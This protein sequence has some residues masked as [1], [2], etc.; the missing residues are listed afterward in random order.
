MKRIISS[1]ALLLFVTPLAPGQTRN[2]PQLGVYGNLIGLT[3]TYGNDVFSKIPRPWR[4]GYAIAYS[5]RNY[6]GRPEQRLIYVFGDQLN[7][8]TFRVDTK[9]S[10][11]SAKIVITEDKALEIR[12]SFTWD[13]KS[14][15]LKT[16][17]T[18]TNVAVFD[19]RIIGVEFQFDARLIGPRDILPLPPCPKPLQNVPDACECDPCPCG[20]RCDPGALSIYRKPNTSVLAFENDPFGET[21]PSPD[22]RTLSLIWDE[23]TIRNPILRPRAEI[24]VSA[25]LPLA[26]IPG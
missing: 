8:K 26:R 16:Q 7:S 12:R 11:S 15:S 25:T 10:T 9:R 5:L 20:E 18:I 19:L 21:L 23:L 2:G 24:N 22:S 3:D 13:E 6:K 1:L 14:R 17:M 4:E